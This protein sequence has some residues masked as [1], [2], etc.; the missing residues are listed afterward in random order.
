[1]SVFDKNNITQLPI[2]PHIVFYL[3]QLD[4]LLQSNTYAKTLRITS[5][6]S[7][8][9][10]E[11]F[12]FYNFNITEKNTLNNSKN[13]IPLIDTIITQQLS[14]H[15]SLSYIAKKLFLCEKQVSRIIKQEYGTTFPTLIKQ[16]KLSVAAML[17]TKTD[18]TI[19]EIADILAFNTENYFFSIFKKEY[20]C[21]PLKYRKLHK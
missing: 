17:L 3:S 19:Q 18:M 13:Y 1:M 12:G 4:S 9:F 15:I 2:S 11:I 7:L 8:L 10:F 14:E 16:K 20:G 21:S 5:V 6:L